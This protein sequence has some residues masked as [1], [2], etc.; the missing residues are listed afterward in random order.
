MIVIAIIGIVVAIGIPVFK[1]QLKRAQQATDKANLREA[2]SLI[3]AKGD[4]AVPGRLYYFEN[5]QLVEDSS[6]GYKSLADGI[7]PD[8]SEHQ[9]DALLSVW[10][11][12]NGDIHA[13][14]RDDSNASSGGNSA[15][16]G[17]FTD[18]GGEDEEE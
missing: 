11:D 15:A 9:A 5:G 16:N 2:V 8:K 17:N 18:D 12:D 14:Y 13:A 4:D 1:G 10:V 6:K 3:V 7:N